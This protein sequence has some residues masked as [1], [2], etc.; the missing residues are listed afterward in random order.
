MRIPFLL[1]VG[2][3]ACACGDDGGVAMAPD[4]AFFDAN[5]T[6]AANFACTYNGIAQATH[7]AERDTELELLFFTAR[8]GVAPEIEL[9]TFD[10]YFTLGATDAVHDFT[11]TGESLA[12][13]HTCLQMRRD[14][15]GASCISGKKFLVQEG[16]ASITQIGAAGTALQGTFTNLKL[17][18]FTIGPNLST[19]LVPDG[20]S[21]C[22][23]SYS[24]DQAITSP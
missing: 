5:S 15:G 8:A 7:L 6:D 17:A 22:I 10:L 9:L 19:M 12:D 11:F 21:W 2:L 14:C 3:L 18:E 4:A 24:F 20:E 16:T 13:C 1:A 23:D